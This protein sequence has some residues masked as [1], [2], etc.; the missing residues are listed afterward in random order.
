MP[1]DIWAAP[2]AQQPPAAA[3]GVVM[4]K[5][6]I[7]TVDF[8]SAGQMVLGVPNSPDTLTVHYP[9][10][11][12]PIVNHWAWCLVQGSTIWPVAID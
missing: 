9:S 12:T 8:P 4:R 3:P 5:Y 10:S 2:P 1:T 11:L 6:L 7:F